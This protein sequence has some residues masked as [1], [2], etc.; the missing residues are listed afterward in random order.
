[1]LV[2]L[3]EIT[4]LENELKNLVQE[5]GTKVSLEV[6]KIKTM[7][8]D[9]LREANVEIESLQTVCLRQNYYYYYYLKIF[10]N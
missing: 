10:K 3:E 7:Y 5:S 8:K 4:R 2:Y 6:E 1:M 9:R